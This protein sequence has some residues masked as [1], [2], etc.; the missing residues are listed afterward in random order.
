[1]DECGFIDM[2]FKGNPF[3]WKNYFRDGQTIWERLDRS[4][5]NNKWLLRF[6]GSLVL[7]LV[8]NTLDHPPIFHHAR[9]VGTGYS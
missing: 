7:H 5:S 8:L 3:T 2:G 1:M 4:L 6:G 9:S